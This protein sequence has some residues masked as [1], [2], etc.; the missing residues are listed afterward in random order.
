MVRNNILPAAGGAIGETGGGTRRNTTTPALPPK[1]ETY[2]RAIAR[3]CLPMHGRPGSDIGVAMLYAQAFETN[4]SAEQRSG[5][6]QNI[7]P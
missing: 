7:V 3:R 6:L 4:I 2:V 1:M 5:T